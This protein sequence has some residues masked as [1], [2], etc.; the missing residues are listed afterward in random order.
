M[1]L[2]YEVN[3][4]INYRIYFI[5]YINIYI[6]FSKIDLIKMEFKYPKIVNNNRIK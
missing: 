1:Y 3:N 5:K 2:S 4:N 6:I